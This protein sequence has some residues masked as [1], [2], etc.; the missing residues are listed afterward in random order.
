VRKKKADRISENA[1]RLGLKCIKVVIGDVLRVRSLLGCDLMDRVLVDAP[2]SN[3]GVLGKRPEARW[4]LREG[5][6]AR[7][8]EAQV[9]LLSAAAAIVRP[10]GV[11]VYSTCSIEPD[12]NEKVVE[13]FLEKFPGFRIEDQLALYP[14]TSGCDG[15]YAAR[16]VRKL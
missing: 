6:I 11:L 12:E 7:L 14:H 16:L 15:G 8:A 2:C 13:R 1:K 9:K 3:T 5:D 10:E 4:R